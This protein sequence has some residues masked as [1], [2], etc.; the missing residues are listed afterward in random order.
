[1]V[2]F[3]LKNRL[4]KGSTAARIIEEIERQQERQYRIY[5]TVLQKTSQS[6][7]A[8]GFDDAVIDTTTTGTTTDD[9][10]TK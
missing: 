5:Y 9:K 4:Y 10:S 1:M 8:R 3:M 6:L 2:S 7:C